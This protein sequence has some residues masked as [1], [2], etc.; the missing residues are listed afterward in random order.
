[1]AH[2]LLRQNDHSQ[3]VLLNALT[4]L[5]EE[6]S[7]RKMPFVLKYTLLHQRAFYYENQIYAP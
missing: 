4:D 2:V 3:S 6:T 7:F 1:M 5:P